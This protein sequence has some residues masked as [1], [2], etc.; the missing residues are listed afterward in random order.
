MFHVEHWETFQQ[1]YRV[2]SFLTVMFRVEQEA[3]YPPQ[4][5]KSK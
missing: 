2:V 4:L 1:R 5:C 3:P